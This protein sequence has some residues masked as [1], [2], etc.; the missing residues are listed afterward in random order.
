MWTTLT[1]GE[2]VEVEVVV[3]DV[4]FE[5]ISNGLGVAEFVGFCGGIGHE[6][7]EFVQRL[8]LTIRLRRIVS[9]MH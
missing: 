9:R 4:A 2:V 5:R 7:G 3:D 6:A 1:D 8:S